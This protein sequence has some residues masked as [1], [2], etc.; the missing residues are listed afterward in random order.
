MSITYNS[1][2]F[3][4]DYICPE[5]GGLLYTEVNDG[6]D[7]CV[8]RNC[9]HFP[10]GV[11]FS[12]PSKE[13]SPWLHSELDTAYAEL[14]SNIRE[15]DP[16]QLVLYVYEKRKALIAFALLSGVMPSIPDFWALGEL[17]ITL[18]ANPPQGNEK[19]QI[20]FESIFQ[21]MKKR[22]EYLNF[23]DDMENKRLFVWLSEPG[24]FKIF[25]MKYLSV[26]RD[27]QRSYGIA[28]S[29]S[30]KDASDLF[31]FQDIQ[32]LVTKDVQLAPGVDYADF[33]DSLWPYVLTLRYAFSMNYRTSKQYDYNPDA[34]GVAAL[35]S[36]FSSIPGDDTLTIPIPQLRRH[37][38]IQ[39]QGNKSF[40]EF[41]NQYVDSVYKVPIM[42]RVSNTIIADRLTL[43]YFVIYLH[44]QYEASSA[45][46]KGG[47]SQRITKKK[48]EAG[49]VFEHNLR[50]MISEHGYTG[51]NEAIQAKF[52]YDVMKLSE[53]K[54]QIILADAKFRDPSPSSISGH[55][56]I[57]QEL[58]DQNQG[59][60]AEAE[61]QLERLEYFKQDPEK[62]RKY[63]NPEMDW[64]EYEI[65][66]Y[67]V[68][69]HTPL[70]D[71]Y[72][73]IGIMSA[74]DFLG[75]EL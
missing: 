46:Q 16:A 71:R 54:K 26:I 73:D 34:F 5:C 61:R 27:M 72:K 65:R 75:S 42:V 64:R 22:T 7:I 69:K 57:Q 51:P 33:L 35:L 74:S 14:L 50:V 68:T 63:L 40:K 31:K 41:L 45:G 70:I 29:S 11:Q 3:H 21:Q 12:D 19:D 47:G 44:G 20:F 17:L 62:F 60:L 32:E 4:S 8:N 43:L 66:A 55:T 15:S 67:L 10:A 59:L 56:L 25:M 2:D 30:L 36:C 13:G 23:V 48:Q 6:F 1:R 53:V 28:S 18:N 9:R 37:F 24:Q 38:K 58:L 39:P 52:D 49:E